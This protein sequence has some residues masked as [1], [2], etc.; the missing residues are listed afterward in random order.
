MLDTNRDFDPKSRRMIAIGCACLS[1][2]LMLHLLI[3]P[4]TSGAR[5]FVHVAVGLL[6]GLSIGLNAFAFQLVRRRRGNRA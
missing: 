6:L 1:I 3:H 4:S 2:G 5:I